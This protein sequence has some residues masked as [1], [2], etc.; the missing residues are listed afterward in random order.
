MPDTIRYAADVVCLRGDEVLLIERG[1][2]PHKG[3]LALAGGHVDPGETSR[4]AAVR[5]LFEETGVRVSEDALQLIGVYDEP[6]RDPR[7]WYVSVAYLVDVPPDTTAQAGDDAATVQW[8]PL[9]D[10]GPLA[11]DHS[12]IVR[13]ARML[14]APG[15]E[16]I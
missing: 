9:A 5:E 2:P 4:R 6:G 14:R 16:P 11:F 12:A 3:E 10:P 1:W 7:G 13:A 15:P 8:R